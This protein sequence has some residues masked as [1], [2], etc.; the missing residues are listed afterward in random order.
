[1]L[2]TYITRICAVVLA[3]FIGIVIG[4][5]LDLKYHHNFMA[6]VV[7]DQTKEVDI[8]PSAGDVLM[9]EKLRPGLPA[10]LVNADFAS[11]PGNNPCDPAFQKVTKLCVIQDTMNPLGT[12]AYTCSKDDDASFYCNDPGVGPQSMSGGTLLGSKANRFGLWHYVKQDLGELFGLLPE[13]LS[14][15]DT[16]VMRGGVAVPKAEEPAA[17]S[18]QHATARLAPR[19]YTSQVGCNPANTTTIVNNPGNPYPDHPNLPSVNI[20]LHSNDTLQWV[21]STGGRTISNPPSICPDAD[22]NGCYIPPATSTAT[23]PYNVTAEGCTISAA[24]TLTV[25]P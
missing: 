20:T 10:E 21:S 14:P 6:F 13:E 22:S 2:W 5:H 1:M 12:Y 16:S 8:L 7:Q 15:Y 4:I 23:Y 3:L 11:G 19:T 17:Q 18:L 24:L 9:W 25:Q